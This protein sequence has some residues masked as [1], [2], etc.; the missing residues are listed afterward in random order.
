MLC[1]GTEDPI[2]LAGVKTQRVKAAL[3]FCYVVA[4]DHGTPKK[5]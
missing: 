4:A 1:L 3:E 5:Q 2:M